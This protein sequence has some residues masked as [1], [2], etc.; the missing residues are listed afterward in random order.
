MTQRKPPGV[1]F[2]TW[3]DRQIRDATERGE[4]DDLPGRGKPIGDLEQPLDELWWVRQKMRR[5]NLSYLPPTL[6]LR[7]EVEDVL[8]AV[9]RAGSEAA[10]REMVT[11]VNDKIR[12]A[13]RMAL[14]GPPLNLAPFDVDALVARW[15][16]DRPDDPPPEQLA[17]VEPVGQGEP[18]RPRRRRLRWTRRPQE[19][20]RAG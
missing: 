5:E 1:T 19:R 6:A 13:N 7:K 16:A 3:I 10:V 9:S 12:A 14:S 4:F 15:Q 2:E 8:A 20:R 11:A 17:P 18:T